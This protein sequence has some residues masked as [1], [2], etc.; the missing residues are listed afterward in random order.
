MAQPSG[1]GVGSY[2][3][4][5]FMG[6]TQQPRATNRT[7]PHSCHPDAVFR[8]AKAGRNQR[9]IHAFRASILLR[10]HHDQSLEDLYTGV[11]GYLEKRVFEHK[12]GMKGNLPLD[13]RSTDSCTL[14]A[15]GT[16]DQQLRAKKQIKG[17]LR[18]KKMTLIVSMNPVW[19]DLSASGSRG[20]A[21]SR[22]APD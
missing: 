9:R 4:P 15:L 1:A 22:I 2:R 14:S 3:L 5:P 13:T 16:R 7:A 19:R 11:T 8:A 21:S 10:L 12:Q 18:V 20:I 6:D 17:L